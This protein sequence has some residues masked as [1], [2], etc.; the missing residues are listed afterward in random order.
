MD[1]ADVNDAI[2]QKIR[3]ALRP[4]TSYLDDLIQGVSAFEPAQTKTS[5]W[6][7][8]FAERNSDG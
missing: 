4:P 5:V 8:V 3:G 2:L 6:G 1:S 7:F